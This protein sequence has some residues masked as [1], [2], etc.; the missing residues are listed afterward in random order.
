MI[1][2]FSVATAHHFQDALASQAKLRF[3][4]FVRRR[5]LDHSSWDGLEFDEFDTPAAT[6]LV[7]RDNERVVRGSARL[8]RTTTPYMLRSYWPHLVED[9]VLPASVGIFEV[10]RVCVDKTVEPRVRATIFPE[11]LC[12]IQE[13]ILQNGGS[14][15]IG[16]TREHLLAHFVRSGIRWLGG[17]REIEGEMERAFYVPVDYIRPALHCRKLGIG[18]KVLASASEP[19][20]ARSAA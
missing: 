18:P 14:G 13:F 5:G 20:S 8:L 19:L 11:L 4:V 3:E 7:W 10:T 2:A 17:A 1:E 15:M 6:Y 9:G 16:V 12:A